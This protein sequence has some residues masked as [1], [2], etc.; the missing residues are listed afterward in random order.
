[1]NVN[2]Q[3]LGVRVFFMLPYENEWAGWKNFLASFWSGEFD[4]SGQITWLFGIRL[5]GISVVFECFEY[6]RK[7]AHRL[8][9]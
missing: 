9:E 8:D 1:M 4:K 2:G 5:V 7:A 3:G 6:D